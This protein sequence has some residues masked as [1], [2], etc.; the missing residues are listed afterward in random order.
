MA[1]RSSDLPCMIA[2]THMHARLTPSLTPR[3]SS[4]AV[5]K[6]ELAP[7]HS[8]DRFLFLL[9]NKFAHVFGKPRTVVLEPAH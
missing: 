7:N 1:D 6:S 4:V 3:G 8:H 9:R 5:S 2:G